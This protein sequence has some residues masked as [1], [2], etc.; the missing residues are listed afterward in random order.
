MR[1]KF[2]YSFFFIG[3]NTSFYIFREVFLPLKIVYILCN[4]YIAVRALYL[5][6]MQKEY[7]S[8]N[9][10]LGKYFIFFLSL[11]LTYSFSNEYFFNNL[12]SGIS[13][14]LISIAFLKKT[15]VI[16]FNSFFIGY[17]IS[18]AIN[19]IYSGFE[20]ILLL[21]YNISINQ[22]LFEALNITG[23]QNVSKVGRISGLIWDPYLLGI[24]CATSFFIFK[25]KI[26]KIYI[27]IILYYSGSRSGYLGF[28]AACLYYY[29]P[30]FINDRKI[31]FALIIILFSLVITPIFITN[32][33]FGKVGNQNN[34]GEKRR[35]EY[36]T[37][38]PQIWESDNTF[39]H[40][41][42]GGAP[43]YTGA[44]FYYSKVESITKKSMSILKDKWSIESDWSGI[45]LGRGLMGFIYYL[46]IFF[47]ILLKQ[48]NRKLKAISVSIFF[49]GVGYN[50]DLA[51]FVNYILFFASSFN[52]YSKNRNMAIINEKASIYNRIP[53]KQ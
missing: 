35:L 27:I 7:F 12:I 43:L 38:I 9:I 6:I 47:I 18:L 20:L 19:F 17:K 49:A 32:T 48:K 1:N 25:N 8:K 52:L 3:L 29:Y 22:F 28:L 42:I 36:F 16:E 2:S 34:V 41:L 40:P 15:N 4:V 14:F 44:R 53:T 31:I 21:V 50:Y 37:L 30:I 33:R 39:L 46:Y 13:I 23:V 10:L 51:I 24:F 5:L 45:L 11:L 26:I